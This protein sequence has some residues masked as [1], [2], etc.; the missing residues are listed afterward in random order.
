MKFSRHM[1]LPEAYHPLFWAV[2]YAF[3]MVV[4]AIK[5]SLSRSAAKA[6]K[7]FKRSENRS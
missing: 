5:I 1:R 2:D 7:L 3:K 4:S 6:F